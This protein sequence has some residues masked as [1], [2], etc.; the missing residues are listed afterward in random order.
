MH[1]LSPVTQPMQC[2][3]IDYLSIDRRDST[4]F[5]VLTVI[6]DFT[7]YGFAFEVRTENAT[8]TAK[9]L[10]R[11]VYSKFGFPRTVHSDNGKPFISKVMKEL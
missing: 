7:K 5:K 6:E 8:N 4:K 10:F 9:T 1:H 3:C 11:H 2:I